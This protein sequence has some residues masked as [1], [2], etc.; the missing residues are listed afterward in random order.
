MIHWKTL[1]KAAG[2]VFGFAA[3]ITIF[4]LLASRKPIILL[5]IVLIGVTIICYWSML[6]NYN[7]NHDDEN[8]ER[9]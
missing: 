3:L 8:D 9:P 5:G 1:F 2:I 4:L 7:D 6:D